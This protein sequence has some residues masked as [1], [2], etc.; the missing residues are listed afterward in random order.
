MKGIKIAFLLLF[1]LMLLVPLAAFRRGTGLV[2]EIDN[3][4]LQENPLSAG[5]R[6]KGGDLTTKLEKYVQDRIG[7]RSEM[8]LGYT[9]LNDRVFGKMVHPSYCYGR[10]GYVYGRPAVASADEAYYAAFAGMAGKIRDYCQAR[11]VPF[12][13]VLEPMKESV[14][15]E[16]LPAGLNHDRRGMETLLT[17]LEEQ[18]VPVLDAAGILRE[19][20]EAGEAVFNQVFDAGH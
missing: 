15:P 1:A 6:A 17:L 19:R 7:F 4:I 16:Y 9:V 14:L 11:G 5:E 10:E 8:I 13:L 3:R 12:L 20:T 2:S 18:G